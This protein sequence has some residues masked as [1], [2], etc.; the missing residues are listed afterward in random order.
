MFKWLSFSQSKKKSPKFGLK[1]LVPLNAH[2]EKQKFFE[3]NFAY[4]PQFQ[5]QQPAPLEYLHRQGLPEEKYLTMA[6]KVIQHHAPIEEKPGPFLSQNEVE[7][8]IRHALQQYQL[9]QEYQIVFSKSFVSRAAIN[10]G[11]KLIKF[12]LPLELD[13]E[14]LTGII[15]HEID[16]H[17]LRNW[18]YQQQFWY[19]KRKKNGL[20]H[21]WTL[22]EEGLA[23]IHELLD[24][25][26]QSLFRSALNYVAVDIAL[27]SDFIAV[28]QFFY[29]HFNHDFER[30]WSWALKK[31]RGLTD[32]SQPGGLTKDLVYFKGALNVLEWLVHHDFALEKLYYG[33]IALEDVEKAFELSLDY[34]P[35]TPDFYTDKPQYISKINQIQIANQEIFR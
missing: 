12:R 6:K 4:N 11:D 25:K 19:K 14:N 16:T 7:I 28:F 24:K 20:T 10:T 30:S 15:H 26:D 34:Q 22:T 31:K 2:S 27:Q 3:S 33:K 17:L 13:Q 21:S 8:Q 1:D 9:E 5:Y 23:V 32:T 35:V 18:N 29:R